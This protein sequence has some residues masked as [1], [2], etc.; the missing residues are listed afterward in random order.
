[1]SVRIAGTCSN[2]VRGTTRITTIRELRAAD[3]WA[4]RCMA[5]GCFGAEVPEAARSAE[6]RSEAVAPVRN[7]RSMRRNALIENGRSREQAKGVFRA[8]IFEK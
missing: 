5:A 1:M 2:G 8:G 7:G 6:G 3:S 4:V